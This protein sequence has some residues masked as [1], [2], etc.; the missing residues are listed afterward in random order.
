MKSKTISR[1]TPLAFFLIGA[2]LILASLLYFIP[3]DSIQVISTPII[4]NA[5]ATTKQEKVRAGLPVRLEIP[6]LSMNTV[7]ENVGL[8][9][10]GIIDLPKSPIKAAW[11]NLGPRPG[12][13]G[14]AIIIGHY[15][16]WKNGTPTIFNN[17]HKLRQGDKLYIKDEKGVIITFVVSKL[18]IYDKSEDVSSVFNAG[19]GKAHLNLVTCAGVWNNFSKSYPK[20]LIVFS[21]QEIK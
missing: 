17:L 14:S 7:L 20:W 13:N 10:R 9:S 15:G 18:V 5:L 3:R 19:D 1:Q 8:T 21:D 16:V 4:H 2:M 12:D 11:F 6:K